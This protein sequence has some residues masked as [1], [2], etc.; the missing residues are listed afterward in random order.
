MFE[1]LSIGLRKQRAATAVAWIPGL[2]ARGVVS[3]RKQ[4]IL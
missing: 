3:P 4:R 1:S 2:P